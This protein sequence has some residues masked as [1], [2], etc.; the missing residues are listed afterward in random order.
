MNSGSCPP[1][2]IVCPTCASAELCPTFN[3]TSMII[4]VGLILTIIFCISVDYFKAS[5]GSS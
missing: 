1:S 5:G 4:I 3:Q 2:N